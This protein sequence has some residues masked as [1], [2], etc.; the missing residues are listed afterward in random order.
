MDTLGELSLE[1]E[2]ELQIV[3]KQASQLSLSQ[4]QNYIVEMMRQMMI[5]DNLVD[6]LLTQT[7]LPQAKYSQAILFQRKSA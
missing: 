7:G 5:R 1:Q 2:L 4:A 3:R 6:H